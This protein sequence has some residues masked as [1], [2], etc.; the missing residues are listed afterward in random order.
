MFSSAHFLTFTERGGNLKSPPKRVVFAYLPAAGNSL[1]FLLFSLG[2]PLNSDIS[3]SKELLIGLSVEMV[4]TGLEEAGREIISE[5]WSEK[6][7]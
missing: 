3:S 5:F 1:G 7:S 6:K 2:T 4:D